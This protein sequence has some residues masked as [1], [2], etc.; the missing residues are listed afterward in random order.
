[1]IRNL[2][3]AVATLGAVL[4]IG[5]MFHVLLVLTDPAAPLSKFTTPPAARW[6]TPDPSRAPGRPS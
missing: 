1:M 4:G 2:L 5:L 6:H 3:A